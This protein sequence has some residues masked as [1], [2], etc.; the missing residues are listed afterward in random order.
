MIDQSLRSGGR[1]SQPSKKGEREGTST[2]PR[3]PSVE[4][5]DHRQ[6]FER[7]SK[8]SGCVA[9]T[10][11]PVVQEIAERSRNEQVGNH[12]SDSERQRRCELREHDK[13]SQHYLAETPSIGHK[14]TLIFCS[15]ANTLIRNLLQRK[16][17]TGER[18]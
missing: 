14:L 15:S 2:D 4:E 12:G 13:R 5:E 18:D 8:K 9:Q 17:P 10:L 3:N 16:A 6:Q 11:L 1:T 7:V